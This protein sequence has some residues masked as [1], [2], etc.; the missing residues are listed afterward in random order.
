MA[1]FPINALRSYAAQLE[2]LHLGAVC[3][4]QFNR[5]QRRPLVSERRIR[6]A[7]RLVPAQALKPAVGSRIPHPGEIEHRQRADDLQWRR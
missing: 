7:L 3:G 1:L 6:L 5:R 2:S 4:R